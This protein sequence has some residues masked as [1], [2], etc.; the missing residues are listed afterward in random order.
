MELFAHQQRGI[1]RGKAQSLAYFWDCGTGK[2]VTAL[3]LIRYH[4][5]KALVVCPLSIIEPAWIADCQRFTPDLSIASLW[6]KTPAKRLEQLNGDA[7]IHVVNYEGL[8]GLYD[9]LAQQHYNV[10]IVDESSKMKN[11]RSQITRALLSFAG[12]RFKDSPYRTEHVIPHRYVLSGTPAPNDESEYW[13]QVT[14]VEP[15]SAFPQNYFAFRNR[16]FASKMMRYGKG[17]PFKQWT[18]IEAKKPEFMEAMKAMADVVRKED[19]VDLPEQVHVVR[20]VHLSDNEQHAYNAMKRFLACK[21]HDVEIVAPT[22]MAEI[23]KLRQITSG[24]AYCMDGVGQTGTI[25]I[26]RSKLEELQEILAEIGDSQVIIWANFIEEIEW[27]SKTLKAPALYSQTPNREK[28]IADFQAGKSRY[29]IANPQSAGHGLTFV[30]CS[31]CVYFSL[32][33]SYELWKQSMDRIH[34][35]GQANRCTY[36]YLLAAGSIDEIIYDALQQKRNLSEAVL[37]YL[38]GAV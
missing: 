1:E 25:H 33:Y 28:A 13:A 2:T 38:K 35:I 24:F 12:V 18:F 27:L 36:F 5:G 6:S 8:K 37:T 30:N 14:L 22:V 31:Y 9:E 15:N 19:A 10:L 3:N 29:L 23:M 20:Q 32:N 11:W 16:Y 7:Q 26:G 4:G 17:K 34:R 21:V